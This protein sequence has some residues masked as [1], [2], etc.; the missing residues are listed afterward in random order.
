[1]ARCILLNCVTSGFSL[2]SPFYDPEE[3]VRIAKKPGNNLLMEEARKYLS[4]IKERFGKF[5]NELGISLD[6]FL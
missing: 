3:V 4:I 5:Y 2:V 6:S 1:M